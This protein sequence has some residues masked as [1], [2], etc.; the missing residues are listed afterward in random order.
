MTTLL[1][2]LIAIWLARALTETLL[3]LFQVLIGLSALLLA[4]ALY[5]LSA[6]IQIL[7]WLWKTAFSSG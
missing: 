5:T 4:G 7:A 2:V 6:A 1:S 3:G